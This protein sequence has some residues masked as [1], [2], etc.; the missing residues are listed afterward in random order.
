M[1]K[2]ILFL[3]LLTGCREED[4]SMQIIYFEKGKTVEI[5]N[6]KLNLQE[7]NN[8]LKS[9]FYSTDDMLKVRVDSTRI[10]EIMDIDSGIEI[11]F[12]E[13]QQFNSKDFGSFNISKLLIPFSGDYFGNDESPVIT[14]FAAEEDYLTGP[15]RNSNGLSEVKKIQK[16][17]KDSR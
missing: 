9:L 1:I 10:A 14:I 5:D 6:Q 8:I 16:M 11:N 15:L 7:L 17:I 13:P 2:A 3:L 4:K 12:K